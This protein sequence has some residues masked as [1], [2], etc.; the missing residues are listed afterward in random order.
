[1]MDEIF[2]I[3]SAR[4]GEPV[5]DLDVPEAWRVLAARRSHRRFL[6]RPLEPAPIEN[7]AALALS[8]PSNGDLEAKIAA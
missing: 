8:A 1:M 7:L 4:F 6:D 3:L 5:D 2:E